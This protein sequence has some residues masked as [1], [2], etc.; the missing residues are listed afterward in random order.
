MTE[1]FKSN[2]DDMIVYRGQGKAY[3]EL[4]PYLFRKGNENIRE[5]EARLLRDAEAAHPEEFSGLTTLD[6]LAKLQHS[7]RDFWT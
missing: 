2:P 4:I 3:Q 6:K 7:L 1:D 5:N